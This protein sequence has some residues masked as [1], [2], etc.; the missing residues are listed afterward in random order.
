DPPADP[1][2]FGVGD[3]GDREAPP[4]RFQDRGE[5]PD[6]RR[7][8]RAVWPEKTEHLSRPC[9]EAETLDRDKGAV[10]LPNPVSRDRLICA[11]GSG[12]HGLPSLARVC[13]RWMKRK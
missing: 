4:G 11:G 8:A 10:G 2:R 12:G 5:N 13:P 3:P 9:R 6:R 1:R 7:F